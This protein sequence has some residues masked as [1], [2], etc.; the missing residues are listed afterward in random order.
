M[1]KTVT[2]Y[3]IFV[4]SPSDLDEERIAIEEVIK[5][6]NLTF[7]A[8]QNIVLELLKW[9]THSAP[10]IS[11]SHTQELIN[12]DIGDEYDIFLGLLWKRFGTPTEKAGSGTEEEFNRAVERFKEK[13]NP[14]Q[15]LFYFKDAV[16]KSLKDINASELLQ[17]EEFKKSISNNKLL[18]WEFDS[19]ESLK[20]FLRLHI[21]IR[22]NTLIESSTSINTNTDLIEIIEEESE[23]GLLDYSEMF[24]NLMNDSTGALIKIGEDIEWI[25]GEI[26]TKA[27]EITRISQQPNPNKN[28]LSGVIKR[29]AKLLNDYTSRLE[30]EIPIFYSSFEEGI[31]AGINLI[32]LADDFNNQDTIMELEE[33][34]ES[35]LSLRASIPEAQFGMNS[36][37]ESIKSLPRIQKDIN[38]AKKKLLVQLED[39]IDKFNKTLSLSE[40]Y[41]NEI[42]NKI[43]KLKITIEK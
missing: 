29:T 1:A 2:K 28:S 31:Q 14:L 32:N 25:G 20:N 21:P 24:E 38:T 13:T 9:E 15:V 41:S 4:G 30:I 35:I 12:N 18:Y 16:P 34:K 40:E 19:S 7:G 8:K 37:Y 10:G 5:E 23:Y 3:S 26:T 27:E 42:G 43:D 6:L 39:M 11:D 22:I 36:F 33:S 17:I